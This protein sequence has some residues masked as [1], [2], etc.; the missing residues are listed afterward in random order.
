MPELFKDGQS[1]EVSADEV[2]AFLDR[3][4]SVAAGQTVPVRDEFGEKANL[5]GGDVSAA[6]RQQDLSP[7]SYAEIMA[8]IEERENESKYGDGFVNNIRAFGEAAARG[9]TFG[10]SD[11]ILDLLGADMEDI[12]MRRLYNPNLAFGGEIGGAVLPSLLTFGAGAPASAARFGGIAVRGGKAGKAL[13]A[14]PA[15]LATVAGERA[16]RVVGLGGG[17]A[18][19][20]AARAAQGGVEGTIFGAGQGLSDALM[21]DKPLSAE[22]LASSIASN[23][24]FGGAFGTAVGGGVSLASGLGRKARAALGRP[25]KTDLTAWA[26]HLDTKSDEFADVHR[27]IAAD[28]K[29]TDEVAEGV[30]GKLSDEIDR[31][32]I[33]SEVAPETA[34]MRQL[35]ATADQVGIAAPRNA[36]HSERIAQLIDV[37]KELTEASERFSKVAPN[38]LTKDFLSDLVKQNDGKA[39]QEVLDAMAAKHDATVRALDALNPGTGDEFVKGLDAITADGGDSVARIKG[40]DAVAAADAL[41]LDVEQL[42]VVG[43]AADKALKLWLLYRVGDI[44]SGGKVSGR[45]GTLGEKAAGKASKAK[46][47]YRK[48]TLANTMRDNAR[49][50]TV[51]NVARRAAPT[52]HTGFV[53]GTAAGMIGSGA[54]LVFDKLLPRAASKGDETAGRLASA[55]GRGIKRLQKAADA[56]VRGV[57]G[58]ASQ[59]PKWGTIAS[60]R[61]LKYM[62]TDDPPKRQGVDPSYA[63]RAHE[64][65][66]AAANPGLARQKIR[67]SLNG[68][69]ATDPLL[70]QQLEVLRYRQMMFLKDRLPTGPAMGMYG[71]RMDNYRPSEGAIARF[72]R[73]A[74]AVEDPIGVLEQ[75]A[76]GR[77]TP[78]AAEA[79]REVYPEIW[80]RARVRIMDNLTEL[81]KDL[82]YERLIQLGVLFDV[83]TS[84]FLSGEMIRFLQAS[85]ETPAAHGQGQKPASRSGSIKT[86]EA[87]TE[88]QKLQE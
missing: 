6:M 35:Q 23:A 74:A 8:D 37:E 62:D 22:A 27:S 78:E 50:S 44:A 70:A 68:I 25:K 7:Q 59:A 57:G 51:I 20:A 82:P 49:R 46:G 47:G 32:N 48:G 83:P 5:A 58:V 10:G 64:L 75:A 38:G 61:R 67:E 34:L 55:A 2:Q 29:H 12:R 16:A 36:D 45:I 69:R 85:F 11:A 18:R 71:R 28:L 76:A 73:Y 13:M 84:T 17:I 65:R 3:G 21:A 4:W 1:I 24:L 26:K 40:L 56:L 52:G 42:P 39:L 31:L 19:T 43:P 41:G 88:A 60:L 66:Q 14:T 15:G 87:P 33:E 30:S 80:Q 9:L 54:G 81:E 53:Q 79:L 63:A 86:T 77:L 72:A